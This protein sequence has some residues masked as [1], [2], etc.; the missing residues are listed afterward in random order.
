MVHLSKVMSL[1]L[2]HK[3]ETAHLSMDEE[4]WVDMNEFLRNMNRYCGTNA[5]LED[6]QF[7]VSN[8]EKKRFMLSVDGKRDRKSVV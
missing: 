6:I 7:V 1:L 5:S 8:N 3:P 4:G 2:R